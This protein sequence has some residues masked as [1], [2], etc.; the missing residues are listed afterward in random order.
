MKK[1]KKVLCV[2]FV[3]YIII[4]VFAI[5]N[6]ITGINFFMDAKVS[7]FDA[8]IWTIIACIVRL[9]IPICLI[10]QICYFI[11]YKRNKKSSK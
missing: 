6:S 2:S 1:A 9:T 3:P 11:K 5:I 4:L 8:F 10:Y 7:G